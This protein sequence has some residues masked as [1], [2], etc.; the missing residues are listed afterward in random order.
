MD[1]ESSDFSVP[2]K[3]SHA[4]LTATA[5]T[6]PLWKDSWLKN[7][8]L[9]GKV[10][11]ILINISRYGTTLEQNADFIAND[12]ETLDSPYIGTQVGIIDTSK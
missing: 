6:P 8:P 3:S 12:L 7:I 11:V 10:L 2:T 1:P 4:R 5:Q 9:I